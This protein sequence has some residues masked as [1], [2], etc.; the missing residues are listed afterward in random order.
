MKGSV[1]ARVAGSGLSEASLDRRENFTLE[2]MPD[3]LQ[4]G[5]LALADS[6]GQE[7]DRAD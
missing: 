7:P 6:Y 5:L 2:T 3:D 4:K 1:D